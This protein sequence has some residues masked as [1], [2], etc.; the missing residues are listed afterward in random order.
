MIPIIFFFL[1]LVEVITLFIQ[2]KK[3]KNKLHLDLITNF[4]FNG[5]LVRVLT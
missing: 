3:K 5:H 2:N 1:Q 4:F